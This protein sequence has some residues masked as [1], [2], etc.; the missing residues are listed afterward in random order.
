MTMP[1]RVKPPEVPS[2]QDL[3]YFIVFV[4]HFVLGKMN[5]ADAIYQQKGRSVDRVASYLSRVAPPKRTPLYRGWMIEPE[6]VVAGKIAV[7][8]KIP[9]S[10]SR[11]RNI[12]CFFAD[13]RTTIS[14]FISQMRPR[15]RG[16]VMKLT[17]WTASQVIWT[18]EWNDKIP[19]PGWGSGMATLSSITSITIPQAD[20]SLHDVRVIDSNIRS[21]KELIL[22]PLPRTAKT[23]LTPLSKA[24]CP[25][26]A[27]LNAR[28]AG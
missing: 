6:K 9:I 18:Y 4:Q 28:Y 19:A 2:D 16:Y 23:T 5:V 27:A 1:R 8:H 22:K 11:D 12:A 15:A 17:G 26:T 14:A 20:L 24:D 13:P 7:E 3:A 21:Q 25:P 10:F